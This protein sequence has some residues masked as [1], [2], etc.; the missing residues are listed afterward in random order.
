MNKRALAAIFAVLLMSAAAQAETTVALSEM[1]LCCGACVR[2]VENA[3]KSVTGASVAVDKDAGK[4]TV[5]AGSDEVAQQA[6]DAIAKAG[7]HAKSSHDSIR[8]KDDSGVKAG[9]VSRLAL[10]GVHNCCGGCNVAVKKA[11]KSVA[12]VESDTAKAKSDTIVVEGSFDGLAVI[13]ALN[14][15]GFHVVMS[16]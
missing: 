15:A 14:A 11:L 1:H 6:L 12:G 7:F 3:V 4:A 16:K 13:K 10:K 2:G 5:T 8:M 9:Q